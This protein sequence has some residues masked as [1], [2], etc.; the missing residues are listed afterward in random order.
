MID[1]DQYPTAETTVIN[2]TPSDRLILKTSRP[3][4]RG[5]TRSADATQTTM[6]GPMDA[7]LLELALPAYGSVS[8]R[9]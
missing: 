8:L 3:L 2:A 1:L 7:G 6:I 9:F 5:T 4:L